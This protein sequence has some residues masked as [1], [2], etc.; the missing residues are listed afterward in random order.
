MS[1]LALD[2][3]NPIHDH[4]KDQVGVKGQDQVRVRFK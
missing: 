3:S 1:E 4:G 2:W